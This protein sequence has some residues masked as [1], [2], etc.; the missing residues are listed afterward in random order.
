M[1]R[2][3][4]LFC[5]KHQMDWLTMYKPQMKLRLLMINQEWDV[6]VIE[7]AVIVMVVIAAGVVKWK[8]CN[9]LLREISTNNETIIWFVKQKSLFKENKEKSWILFDTQIWQNELNLSAFRKNW[10]ALNILDD[11][12]IARVHADSTTSF[13]SLIE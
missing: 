12:T 9:H 13:A 3:I 4:Y 7:I 6:S 10:I 8:L 2:C 1:F 5:S 11:R